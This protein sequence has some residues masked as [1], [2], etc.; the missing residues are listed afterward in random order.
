MTTAATSA[1]PANTAVTPDRLMALAHGFWVSQVL[2]SAAHYNFFTHISHGARTAEAVAAAAGTDPTGTRVVLDSLAAVEVLLKQDG[3]YSLAPDAEAF[4]VEGR[5]ANMSGMIAEHPH[6]LWD[7][8]GKLREGLKT[9]PPVKPAEY[10]EDP[11]AES[12]FAHLIRVIMPL[13]FAPADAVAEHLGAG[14][15]RNALRILD[16]G[17]GS[18]AWTMPFARRDAAAAITAFDLP[19]VITETQKIVNEVG[20]GAHYRMQPGDLTRD[21]FGESRYDVAVLGNICHG[22][23]PEQNGN[24]LRRLH[25]ALAPGGV[26]VIADMVPDEDR[27]G[28][29][30]PVLFAVNMYLLTEGD[31]WPFSIYEKW[32]TDAGFSR[33]RT[34][35][36]H[37]SHSPIILADR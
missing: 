21:D 26:L 16:V 29:P 18:G 27:S 36:T 13:A 3:A 37:R 24:L 19:Q 1:A 10:T 2:A 4:L 9:R 33:P 32:L 20:L 34:F 17:A 12:F 23:T 8:W 14:T 30:F 15:T 11:G 28:P 35:D 22:L 6:L 25:R 7:Q 31:T 5:P